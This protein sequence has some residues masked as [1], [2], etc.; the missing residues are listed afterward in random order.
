MRVLVNVFHPALAQSRANR[1]WS[2][3]AQEAGFQVRDV[4][5]LYP[6]EKLDIAA[7]QRLCEEHDVLVFQHP[8]HWYG[9]PS[10]MKKWID[11][12]LAFGWAYGEGAI[13]RGKR[14]QS[15]VTVGA[16]TEEYTPEGSRRYSVPEFLR[17]Y[18]RTAAFCGLEWLPPFL[19]YGAGVIGDHEILTSAERY[20]DH[21][22]S[23]TG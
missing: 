16:H 13:I 9:A 17:P 11:E 2:E 5:R 14:W 19:V 4:Y 23:L 22:R 21:L 18:E 7:E 20:A 10:L 6:D 15:A 12:V 1:R 3:A 8:L